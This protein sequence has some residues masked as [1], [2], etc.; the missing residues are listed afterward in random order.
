MALRRI[1]AKL[2]RR[3]YWAFW[4]IDESA[5]QRPVN[6]SGWPGQKKFAVVLT[7]DV[8]GPNGLAKVKQLAELEMELGFRSSFNFVPNGSYTVPSELRKWLTDRG[9]E[10]GVHDLAHDGKLFD[11]RSRFKKL[12][13]RINEYLRSWGAVGFRAGF[14][15]RNLQ[16]IHDLDIQY[17]ASTFDTDP[18][19]PQSD[20]TGTIFPHW[21]PAPEAEPA[22]PGITETESRLRGYVELPYTLAQD[23]TLFLIFR[24]TTIELWRRKLD[25]ISKKGGMAL[26]NVHPDYIHFEESNSSART[27]S[28]NKFRELLEYILK[29]YKGQYWHALPRSVAEW[30]RSR[31]LS[32]VASIQPNPSLSANVS[33]GTSGPLIW[34]DLDNTPHVPFFKP[35]IRELRAKGYR[36]HVTARDAFQVC[37]LA[38]K[39]EV[40][41]DKIGRHYGK[42]RFSKVAGLIVRAAQLLPVVMHSRPVIGLSH[43]SRSQL[44]ICNLF[45]IPTILIMDYEFTSSPPLVR[46]LWEIVPDALPGSNL[47]AQNSNRIL[48][49][50]GIKEDVYVSEFKPDPSILDRLNLRGS[51]VIVTAR[52]PADEAHYH[53]PESDVFFTHFMNRAVKHA[54]IKIV[55]LPRNKRQE[56]QM[57]SNSPEWFR[58]DSVIVPGKA[59]DGVNLLWYSDLVVSGGG[60]MNREAAALGVPVYSIFRGKIGAVDHRLHSEG[61]LVLIESLKQL[62]AEILLVPRARDLSPDSRHRYAL[63]DIIGH[64]E[65]IIAQHMGA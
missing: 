59:E 1:P 57:R 63:Q 52:P 7:H 15:L 51:S 35:I 58:G 62:D 16:W 5:G 48:K 53:N 2:K 12:A 44:L 24:E 13:L 37:A 10:I 6:W 8:E 21:M 56:D 19:E 22:N 31:I 18:F 3:F 50:R 33:Q 20:G 40:E 23:S 43:G 55:L 26:V 30:F 41:C 65:S 27:F 11:S 60:T 64:V 42:N 45:R 29:N 39:M 4:P 25:W 54:K 9:F 17:D 38:S 34:I 61:R 14:M 36:V 46:P 32:P 28:A 47:H 49:Y